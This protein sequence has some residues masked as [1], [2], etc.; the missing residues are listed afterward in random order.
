MHGTE[1]D[2]LR[3]AAP[4]SV[5]AGPLADVRAA[6]MDRQV[7]AEASDHIWSQHPFMVEIRALSQITP[8][9]LVGTGARSC[10][11]PVIRQPSE[12]SRRAGFAD[13][14]VN[15][16]VPRHRCAPEGGGADH[17]GWK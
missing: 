14:A 10:A 9:V 16:P 8:N 11:S 17:G 13:R 6:R 5:V 2:I 1:N 12:V 3:M 4:P 7:F 15:W